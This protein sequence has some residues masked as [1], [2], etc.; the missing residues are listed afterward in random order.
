M[1]S[2]LDPRVRELMDKDESKFPNL[3]GRMRK[4]IEDAQV[5]GDLTLTTAEN[6]LNYYDEVSDDT[7]DVRTSRVIL[8]LYKVF[9][10]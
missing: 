7:E 8:K 3:I 9:G 5:L 4:E 1:L 2:K 10:K 6:L